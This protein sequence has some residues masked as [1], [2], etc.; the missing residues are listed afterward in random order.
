[1]ATIVLVHGWGFDHGVW[2]AV[3]ARL[4]AAHRVETLDFGFFG[5]PRQPVVDEAVIAV[6]HSLGACWWLAQSPIPWRRLLLINGFPRFTETADYAPAVAPRVLAR[7]RK[8]FAQQPAAVLAEFRALCG[9]APAPAGFDTDRLAAGLDWLAEWDGRGVLRERAGE[10]RAL[11]ASNDPIV[12]V[13]MSRAALAC[14]PPEHVGFV[15]VAGHVLP[16]AAPELCAEWIERL[17]AP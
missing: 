14:L 4:S 3:R 7:M 13:G 6:G 12:P 9:A 11:A 5:A 17:A 10:I 15:D 1:M 2:S 8:T 16:L